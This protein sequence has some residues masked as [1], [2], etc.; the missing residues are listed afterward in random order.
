MR[1]EAAVGNWLGMGGYA[2]YVW[3]AFGATV[4]VLGGLL[5]S[6]IRTLRA[7]ESVLADLLKQEAGGTGRRTRR[8]AAR[9]E[10]TA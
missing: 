2:V 10:E 4:L 7:R 1:V 8:R 5:V 6:S 3:P 9:E